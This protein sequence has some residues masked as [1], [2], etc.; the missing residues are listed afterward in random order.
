[1]KK[2]LLV[3]IV[4]LFLTFFNF[5]QESSFYDA[6]F[7]GGVGFTPFW[8]VPNVSSLNSQLSI[9]NYPQVKTSGFY[10]SG[11][12]GFI[13]LGL[14]KNL[15]IGGIAFGGSSS[16]KTNGPGYQKETI[17]SINGGGFTVE[18]TFPFIKVFALSIG[19]ILGGGSIQ[20]NLFKNS[21]AAEWSEVLSDASNPFSNL[22]NRTLKESY[23][24]LS[25]TLNADIPAYRMV[26]FRL[27][28]GYQFTFWNKWSYDNSI[29]L[30]NVPAG[31]DGKSF[32]VQAGIFVGLFS[33]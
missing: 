24:I 16:N 30:Y 18:Y 11:F 15:R 12:D 2:I 4:F 33:F 1:M 17:F 14:V 27:G 5:A 6:P 28:V 26:S 25:P 22:V 29:D 9:F 13:Y 8:F 31:I 3:T 20:V 23:W 7:G 32:F 19:T 21:G 10:S